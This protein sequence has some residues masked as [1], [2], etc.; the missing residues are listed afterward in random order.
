M[1]AR[2]V[3]EFLAQKGL[4]FSVEIIDIDCLK[5]PLYYPCRPC[6]TIFPVWEQFATDIVTRLNTQD[7]L[8]LGC[9]RIGYATRDKLSPTL[10]LSIKRGS[11]RL[12]K[13]VREELIG[14]L[15]NFGLR[16]VAVMINEDA[17]FPMDQEVIDKGSRRI[18]DL[19]NCTEEAR[20]GSSI[21]SHNSE[22]VQGSVGGWIRLKCHQTRGWIPMALTCSHCVLPSPG[23]LPVH[24]RA[25]K[26]C[27]ILCL[28]CQW[29]LMA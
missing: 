10:L 1:T 23:D 4:Q 18:L 13:D 14:P 22:I 2:R 17:I 25:R 21:G 16:D 29:S 20:A 5:T 24:K 3:H 6:D 19:E 26:F 15:E 11:T 9:H 27:S 8:S 28:W 12:W 7:W